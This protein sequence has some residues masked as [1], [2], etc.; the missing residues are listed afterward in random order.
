MYF[1][2]TTKIK[3]YPEIHHTA[4]E[5]NYHVAPVQFKRTPLNHS[6]KIPSVGLT[7]NCQLCPALHGTD[8]AYVNIRVRFLEGVDGQ[9]EHH[10][11]LSDDILPTRLQLHHAL[12]PGHSL[13]WPP[14]LT[15][16]GYFTLFLCSRVP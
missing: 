2:L 1:D 8:I 11:L 6:L 3:V 10:T 9:G 12:Q 15:L 5:P 4:S 7:L 13:G 14:G 16:Q